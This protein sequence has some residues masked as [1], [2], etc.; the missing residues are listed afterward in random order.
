MVAQSFCHSAK[1]VYHVCKR[2][3]FELVVVD[4]LASSVMS[5][6]AF[7]FS[8]GFAT[9]PWIALVLVNPPDDMDS[10]YFGYTG[11][12]CAVAFLLAMVVFGSF[13]GVVLNAAGT[14]FICFVSDR[15]AS[16]S[17]HGSSYAGAGGSDGAPLTQATHVQLV[18]GAFMETHKPSAALQEDDTY[19]KG[20]PAPPV[21]RS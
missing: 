17:Q 20:E 4:S 15:D 6:G 13:T 2:S 18:H 11:G 9:I 12:L 3:G 21:W 10:T 5:M 19:G 14:L 8:V 1:S 7:V 16:S